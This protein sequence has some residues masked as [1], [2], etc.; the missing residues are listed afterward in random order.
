M[1]LLPLQLQKILQNTDLLT[2]V[3]MV[4]LE[5]VMIILEITQTQVLQ[6]L[7]LHL[8]SAWIQLMEMH[9]EFSLPDIMQ[10]EIL[11]RILLCIHCVV[12]Q[13]VTTG[14]MIASHRE[15][16]SWIQ[17]Q[18]S[19]VLPETL[20][21]PL[22]VMHWEFSILR[23]LLHTLSLLWLI[24]LLQTDT[25]GKQKL[26]MIQPAAGLDGLPGQTFITMVLQLALHHLIPQAANLHSR[27]QNPKL[28]MRS[29]L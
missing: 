16:L 15:L 14:F 21:S 11:K 12:Q 29:A 3:Q 28:N 27:L 22:L 8:Q 20:L 4:S 24:K 23:M 25:S 9:W 2:L 26:T 17:I 10:L 18:Y 1:L 7:A 13:E 19:L 6:F 5:Q